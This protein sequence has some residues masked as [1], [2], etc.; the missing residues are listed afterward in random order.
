MMTTLPAKTEPIAAKVAKA[1][2]A[3]M[4]VVAKAVVPSEEK[5]E[6]S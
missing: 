5:E 6:E 4:S 2:K 3:A 1:A